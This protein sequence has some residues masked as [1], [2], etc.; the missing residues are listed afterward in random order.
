MNF[1]LLNPVFCYPPHSF[2]LEFNSV[3]NVFDPL[4]FLLPFDI[5]TQIN[6]QLPLCLFSLFFS[7]NFYSGKHYD[8]ELPI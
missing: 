6:P 2:V 5:V 8:P 3:T 4:S 7:H 1:N